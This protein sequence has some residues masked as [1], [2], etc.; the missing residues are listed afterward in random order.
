MMQQNAHADTFTHTALLQFPVSLAPTYA[1]ALLRSAR[2][3]HVPS[4]TVFSQLVSTR[5]IGATF[6]VLQSLSLH[7]NGWALLLDA[8]FIHE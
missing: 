6:S 5:Y 7:F 8:I 3:L 1:Y 4:E 2:L